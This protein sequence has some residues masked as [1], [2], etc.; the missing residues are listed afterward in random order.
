LKE[1]K[2]SN[3]KDDNSRRFSKEVSLENSSMIW[4]S[5]LLE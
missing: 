1:E 4:V 5:N 3:I 2:G